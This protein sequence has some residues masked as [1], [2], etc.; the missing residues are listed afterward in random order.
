MNKQHTTFWKFYVF[1]KKMKKKKG[2]SRK[3]DLDFWNVNMFITKGH[4]RLS[5]STFVAH[6]DTFCGQC[7][8]CGAWNHT[9]NVCPLAQ[10]RKCLRYGHQ[11][12]QCKNQAWV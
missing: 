11:T 9:Q 2:N 7:Y 1:Y 6:K 5:A 3:I 10:C 12:R 8:M 4:Q